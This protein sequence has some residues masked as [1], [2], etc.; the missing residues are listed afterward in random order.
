M[1][2]K[3]KEYSDLVKKDPVFQSSIEFYEM[4]R[5]EIMER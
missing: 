1:Y 4:S 5:E 3:H 2:E